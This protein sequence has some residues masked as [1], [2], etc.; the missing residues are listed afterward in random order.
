VI[1]VSATVNSNAARTF[2]VP[3]GLFAD[4][5]VLNPSDSTYGWF[6]GNDWHKV[7]LYAVADR[8][9][10]SGTAP[11]SCLGATSISVSDAKAL[12]RNPLVSANGQRAILILAGRTLG[13]ATRP[14]ATLS[15][16]LDSSNADGNSAFVQSNIS[17]TANDRIVVIDQN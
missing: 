12:V 5:A 17:T 1:T 8:H 15:D 16:Y 7:T 9:S 6:T 3:I 11:R 2:T 13:N 10:P 4:H 14:N